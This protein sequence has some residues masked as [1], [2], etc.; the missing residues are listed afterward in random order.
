[1]ICMRARTRTKPAPATASKTRARPVAIPVAARNGA[2]A[3]EG[4]VRAVDD[5]CLVHGVLATGQSIV[6]RC[7]AHV[8][9]SWLRAAT[10][11]AP[12]E[13]VFVRTQPSGT[14]VLWGIFPG[15]AHESI[16]VDIHIRAREVKIDAESVHV[17]TAKAQLK[18][19]RDG[20]VSL[21]GRDVTS[22]ARRVNRIKGGSVRLN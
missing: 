16:A 8:D 17:G 5:A 20:N 21:R 12:V 6:A 22:H 9:R 19:E 3:I 18:L 10:R 4:Q 13:A 7:P 1:M 14:L 15:P 11:V 2:G